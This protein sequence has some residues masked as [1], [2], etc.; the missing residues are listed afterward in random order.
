M[1]FSNQKTSLAASK[2]VI[3]STFMIESVTINYLKF[4]QL[5]APSLHKKIHF[6]ADFLSSTSVTKSESVYPSIFSSDPLPK[7][8]NKSLVLLKYLRIFL[9]AI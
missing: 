6:D 7:I 5:T 1:N 9:T 2:M 3:Y 4:F 8:N